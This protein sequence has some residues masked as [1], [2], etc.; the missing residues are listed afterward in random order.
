ME[1]YKLWFHDLTYILLATKET[2]RV[3]VSLGF[4][5]WHGFYLND[6]IPWLSGMDCD[7]SVCLCFNRLLW[8]I[9]LGMLRQQWVC[10]RLLFLS[11]TSSRVVSLLSVYWFQGSCWVRA[12]LCQY[13][14]PLSQLLVVVHFLLQLSSTSTWL[15][16]MKLYYVIHL[17]LFN[18]LIYHLII[19]LYW[20]FIFQMYIF[21]CV[22]CSEE[23]GKDKH[24]ILNFYLF[25]F[26]NIG[27]SDQNYFCLIKWSMGKFCVLPKILTH[28][29]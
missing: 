14:C 25:I 29:S 13:T 28:K 19:C 22:D 27:T 15:V 7:L 3:L 9:R 21:H 23:A 8:H 26:F 4:I 5:I 17:R 20:C 1:V 11:P 6:W 10:Q 18:F 12:S 24:W 16:K 2:I